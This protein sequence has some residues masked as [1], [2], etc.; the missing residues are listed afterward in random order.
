M[1]ITIDGVEYVSRSVEH[2][3]RCER[4]RQPGE[5]LLDA[6]LRLAVVDVLAASYT[7]KEAA[8]TLGISTRLMSHYSTK[9]HLKLQKR[10][11]ALGLPRLF[12]AV[13]AA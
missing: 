10:N 4:E 6:I 2:Y 11:R 12:R 3:A 13:S 5:H 9:Y 8:E 7:H 1:S